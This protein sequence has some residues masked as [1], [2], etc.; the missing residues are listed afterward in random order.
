MVTEE[1]KNI[2]EMELEIMGKKLI[3]NAIKIVKK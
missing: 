1:R 3:G 2:S